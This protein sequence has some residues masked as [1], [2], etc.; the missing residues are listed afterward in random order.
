[1]DIVSFH[2]RWL[3]TVLKEEPWTLSRPRL[4]LIWTLSGPHLDLI[5]TLSSPHLDL[6]WTSSS[7]SLDLTHLTVD[8]HDLGEREPRRNPGPCSTPWHE[9]R[10]SVGVLFAL[11]W[12]E[13]CLGFY[14]TQEVCKSLAHLPDT[15]AAQW[16][17]SRCGDD[18][19]ICRQADKL[20]KPQKDAA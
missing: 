19:F 15:R 9:D 11:C 6:L 10:R 8:N 3:R 7:P 12:L 14:S 18:V 2:L 20:R 17:H 13:C 5:W 1:M 16:F 4:D